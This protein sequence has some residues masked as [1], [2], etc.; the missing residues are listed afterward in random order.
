MS[1]WSPAVGMLGT[2]VREAQIRAARLG[3]DPAA[4][5][6]LER[7]AAG[8]PTVPS[9][10]DALR[11]GGTVALI[12]E[13]KRRSPSKGSINGAL[14]ADEQARAYERGGAAAISVL[15]EPVHF[16]GDL[17]DLRRASDGTTLP[18]LRKDFHV[19]EAQLLEARVAGASAALLIARALEPARLARLTAFA[20]DLGLDVLLEVRD[21]AE[22][23]RAL[24]TDARVIGVNSRDLET[25]AIDPAVGDRLLPAVPGERVAVWESGI[26]TPADVRRAAAATADAVLVGSHVSASADPAAAVRE[27][28]GV[29]RSSRGR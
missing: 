18:L 25:L 17:D 14:A 4:V 20:L 24:A 12:A 29:A 2:I 11:A 3:A 6:A 28:T 16:D 21:E 15:T 9:F 5:R 10:A 7:A 26:R 19:A 1:T 8:A 23:E 22:L 13:V 27:L